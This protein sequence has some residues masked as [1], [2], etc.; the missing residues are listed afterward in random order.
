RSVAEP[1]DVTL[2]RGKE[3]KALKSAWEKRRQERIGFADTEHPFRLQGS[4]DLNSYKL[5]TEVFWKLLRE[6]GRLGILLPTGIYSDIG[7]RELREALLFNG[8][9]DFL[10]AFQNEKK[11]FSAAHHAFKQVVVCASRGGRTQSFRTLF[12]MGVGDSPVAHAI[13]DD[14]L[15]H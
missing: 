6:D 13:P 7:T 10:Y 1:F 3:D 9:L 4:A 11:V 8:R 15:R 5:F 14:I 12:R 2:A